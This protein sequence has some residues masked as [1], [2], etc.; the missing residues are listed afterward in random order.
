MC[1][2]FVNKFENTLP[3]NLLVQF[4]IDLLDDKKALLRTQQH[5]HYCVIAFVD[6]IFNLVYK[7]GVRALHAF[8]DHV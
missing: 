2:I 1:N 5:F 4:G 3:I 7:Y 8:F 6:D